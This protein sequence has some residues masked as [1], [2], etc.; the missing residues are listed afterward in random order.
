MCVCVCVCVS[1][2]VCVCSIQQTKNVEYSVY[3]VYTTVQQ[4]QVKV[5]FLLKNASSL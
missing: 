5:N 4:G 1:V 3:S 2:C